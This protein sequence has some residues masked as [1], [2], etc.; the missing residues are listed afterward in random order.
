MAER[1]HENGEE[2]SGDKRDAVAHPGVGVEAPREEEGH[3]AQREPDRDHVAGAQGF[4]EQA[5]GEEQ[6]P[7]DPAVLQE[8]GVCRGRPLGGDDEGREAGRVAHDREG[9]GRREARVARA[10]EGEERH[11]GDARPVAGDGE[12]R[13]ADHLDAEA[14]GGP[15]QRR[16]GHEE[17]PAALGGGHAGAARPA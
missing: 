12:R 13:L 6:D 17:R 8:D 7:N 3:A 11:R 15:E 4:V 1:H 16:A 9:E 14:A 10:E 2:E 5:R